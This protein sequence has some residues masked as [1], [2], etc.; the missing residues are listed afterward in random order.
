[1]S[2][3]GERLQREFKPA[4]NRVRKLLEEPLLLQELEPGILHTRVHDDHDGTK[5]GSVAVGM[6]VDGDMHIY[7]DKAFQDLRFRTYAGGGSSPRVHNA[8]RILA[9]AIKLDNKD[10]PQG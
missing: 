5:E 6:A 3:R 9:L 1:M 4:D 8:L 2:R 7:T 10:K